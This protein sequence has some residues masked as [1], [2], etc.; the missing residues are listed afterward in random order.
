MIHCYCEGDSVF[1]LQCK[2]EVRLSWPPSS[3][4]SFL[5]HIRVLHGGWWVIDFLILHTHKPRTLLNL[6]LRDIF[7]FPKISLLF[8]FNSSKLILKYKGR[9][10]T[11]RGTEIVHVFSQGR[12]SQKFVILKASNETHLLKKLKIAQTIKYLV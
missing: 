3:D 8:L 7:S 9:A 2:L 11:C 12:T 1:L 10:V 4:P 6:F 5:S